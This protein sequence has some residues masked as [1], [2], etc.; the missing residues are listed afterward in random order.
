MKKIVKNNLINFLFVSICGIFFVWLGLSLA[1][2]FTKKSEEDISS[3]DNKPVIEKSTI[4]PSSTK[5]NNFKL[6]DKILEASDILKKSAPLKYEFKKGSTNNLLRKQI[7]LAILNTKIG[8]IYQKRVWVYE[9][10][11][12]NSAKNLGIVNLI[13]DDPKETLNIQPRQWNSFNSYFEVINHPELIV[14]GNKYLLLS[15]SLNSLPER[16]AKKFTDIVYSPYSPALKTSE[17]I[18]AGKIYINKIIDEAM[19]KLSKKYIESLSNPGNLVSTVVDKDFLKNILLIEH[20]D[21]DSF[22]ISVDQGRELAER[23]LT[24]VG[25]NLS[26]SYR[27]TGS[28]AGANGLAQFIKSTYLMVLSKYPSAGLINDYYLG[29][30]DHTN[31]AMAMILFFDFYKSDIMLKINQ[32]VKISDEMLI[33]S[34]NGGTTPVIKSINKYGDGWLNAQKNLAEKDQILHS[35]TINYL[36]KYESIVSLKLFQ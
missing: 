21:P 10:D 33:A 4:S 29:M 34:Y 24:I 30:A 20:I 17:V 6:S 36:E 19:V 28:P 7:A 26:H 5:V 18:S 9:D 2:Y 16:S 27:Y 15:S 31:A 11:I 23:M 8:E 32:P 25:C 35:E 3:L 14:I 1:D 13:A 12:N 22:S